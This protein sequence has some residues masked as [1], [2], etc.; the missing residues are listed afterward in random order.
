MQRHVFLYF[1]FDVG[2]FCHLGHALSVLGRKADALLV[3][4]QGYQHALYQCAD[5]KQLLELEELLTTAKQ[6][7]NAFCE[8]HR[9]SVPQSES[10]SPSNGNSSKTYKNQD[11]SAQAEL[12]GNGSDKPEISLKSTE[13]FDSKNEL[14][15]EDRE[16]NKFDGQVNGSPD[17]IDTLGYNSES[18]NDS[19]DTSESCDKISANSSDSIN[20]TETLRNPISK[21]IFPHERKDE[22]KK[23]KKFCVARMSSKMSIS[24]DFR[25]SRGIAEV[26]F[27]AFT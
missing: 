9:L 18:C 21:F 5:L 22:A 7:N 16:S 12:C 10:K 4:E 1:D 23:N 3:W 2:L 24:V 11:L 6:E 19:S 8:T 14:H 15:D 26:C 20:A 25:L 13:N 27:H 17:V